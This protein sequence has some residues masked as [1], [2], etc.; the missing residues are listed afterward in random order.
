MLFGY[1]EDS[2]FSK[3]EHTFTGT[4]YNYGFVYFGIVS[5]YDACLVSWTVDIIVGDFVDICY[6]L[7]GIKM[8]HAIVN[9]LGTEIDSST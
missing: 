8:R 4:Y 3:Y 2:R 6:F 7:E 5:Y 9:I 1:K